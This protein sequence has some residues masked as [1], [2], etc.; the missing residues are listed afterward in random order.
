MN[1]TISAVLR[2]HAD[3]DVHV[4]RLLATVYADVRRRRQR[5]L[6]LTC[7]VLVLAALAGVSGA[8]RSAPRAPDVASAPEATMP[9]PPRVG[10]LPAA[11]GA[12]RVLATDPTLFHLDLTGLTGWNHLAW[13]SRGGL[14]ELVA[15]MESGGQVRVEAH[16]DQARLSRRD[17]PARWVTVRGRP[18]T[19]VDTGG[20]Y[21]IRW[22]PVSGAWA[23]VTAPGD[24]HDA[25][26][27]AATVRLDRV[28]RC[29]V[30]FRLAGV[31]PERVNKC[32][33]AFSV[34][35]D[36]GRWVASGGVWFT[37]RQGGPEYQVGVGS[38]ADPGAANQTIEGRAVQVLG[39]REIRYPYDG[40][41][42]YFWAFD[43][44]A[45]GEVFR[46]LV[47][48]FTPAAGEDPTAWPR[49]PFD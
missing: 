17:G 45:D 33:T 15:T 49:S 7:A 23:Q 36:S 4:E 31:A 26:G 10:G 19:A 18:A 3:G 13:S 43:G 34:D 48:G 12:P 46:S 24:L 21:A 8:M 25:I 40:R 27:L 28:Y 29:A 6:A 16:R 5:R 47:A 14:E 44:P 32:E 22:Q 9:R 39:D 42:A 30:P 11:A 20:S 1:E 41:T 37:T 2:D 35:P 38:G